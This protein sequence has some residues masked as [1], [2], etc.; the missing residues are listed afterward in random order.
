MAGIEATTRQIGGGVDYRDLRPVHDQVL[1]RA[2]VQRRLR[3]QRR[4]GGDRTATT[5]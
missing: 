5:R 2:A 3:A 4:R 1:A